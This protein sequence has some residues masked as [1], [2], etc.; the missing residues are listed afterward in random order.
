LKGEVVYRLNEAQQHTVDTVRLLADREIAPHAERVDRE[1]AF[2]R[3]S[4][5]ALGS[6]G[7]LGLTVPQRSGGMGQGPRAAAAVL[8][9]IAQRCPSTAMVYLMHLCGVACYAAAPDKTAPY[10]SRAAAGSHLST[11]AFSERGSRSHFWAPVSRAV[12]VTRANGANGANGRVRLDAQKSFVTSAGHADGYVVST[13]DPGASTPT[14]S[15]IY[16]VLRDDQGL[17][18]SGAW[19]GLGLRG[20]ASAPMTLNGVSV[21]DD[22]ALS[23]PGKGL[24]VMLGVVLPLF[25]IG[26]AAVALGIAES[27]V[28]MTQQHLTTARLE[29]MSAA[30]AE[31]PTLRAR[32]AQMRIETDRARAH[33]SS[34]LDALEHPGPATQ[35]LVLE[36][37]VAASEAAVTVTDL[38]MRACGG[39]AF[40]GALGL[41]RRFRDARAA[42]V[43]SP[44]TDQAYDFI[45]RALCGLE[46]F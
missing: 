33:L 3:E 22:R 29:H 9:E 11:L 1:G 20:N 35:L 25:Q 18:V 17:T 7:F 26:S 12:P 19:N 38:G 45:G 40:S 2:P 30:L 15:S 37:K 10:L 28:Q 27:A 31:L 23:E 44:T 8:D 36:A 16:L 46:V 32:L 14:A 41:D 5:A 34:V 13:L 39:A 6:A 24:D 4:V 21:C 42:V 43:M